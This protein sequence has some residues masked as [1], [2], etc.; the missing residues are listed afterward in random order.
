MNKKLFHSFTGLFATLACV[1]GLVSCN[2]KSDSESY[3]SAP[4]LAVTQFSLSADEKVPGLESAYFSIDLDNGLIFNA[5][6]L[7]KGTKIDKVVPK[8]TFSSVVTEAVIEMKGG[9]TREGEVDFKKNPTDS[10]DFTGNVTLRIKA[11]NGDISMTY[12]I[13]VNVHREEPDTLVWTDTSLRSI[14]RLPDPVEMKTVENNGDIISLILENDGTYTAWH[15]DS[16]RLD[17]Y[18]QYELHLPFRP[19]VRTMSRTDDA[20]WIL[21]DDGRLWKGSVDLQAWSPTEEYWDNIIGPYTGTVIGMRSEN[22]HR[23]FAQYPVKDLTVREL[24]DDFPVK[25]FSNFVTLENKWTL[26]PVAF[27]TGGE[28]ATGTMSD[29]TWA[30]DGAEWIKLSQGGIPALCGATIIPYYN[31][32][33]SADGNSMVEY[34]VWMLTGGRT[35]DG[36]FNKTVYISYDNGVNWSK[37]ATWLQLPADFPSVYDC[38]NAVVEI[39]RKASLNENP[40]LAESPRR[41]NFR[42]EGDQVIWECPVIYLFGGYGTDGRLQNKVWRGMLN[43]LSFVPLV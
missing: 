9:T 36:S 21:A 19:R 16:P 2:K 7:K 8:I 38:D 39:T 22:G 28:T 20:I 10:I 40:G 31:Y 23:G 32:R 5:D 25:D 1:S 26:S 35:T 42:V 14:S 30:F 34:P 41:V 13:K 15:S 18:T 33:A 27:L 17:Q 3:L 37:G 6:S 24:P 4:N 29:I 43:R 11:D 12:R